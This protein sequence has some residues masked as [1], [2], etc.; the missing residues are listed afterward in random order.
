MPLQCLWL[1]QLLQEPELVLHPSGHHVIPAS[2]N[3]TGGTSLV[4][5]IQ[6]HG[7]TKALDNLG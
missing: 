5:I 6:A 4:D 2:R 3:G 1:L 7:L